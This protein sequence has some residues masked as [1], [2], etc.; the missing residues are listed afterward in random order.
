MSVTFVDYCFHVIY[1]TLLTLFVYV[2]LLRVD[3]IRES[4]KREGRFGPLLEKIALADFNNTT[5]CWHRWIL[6][7]STLVS[8]STQIFPYYC[9]LRRCFLISSCST[10]FLCYVM[11]VKVKD[12]FLYCKVIVQEA[13]SYCSRRLWII[14]FDIGAK[15]NSSYWRVFISFLVL[16][17]IW[18]Q[19]LV[20]FSTIITWK[21]N[22]TVITFVS[23]FI[24]QVYLF[25]QILLF[26]SSA[27]CFRYVFM[28]NSKNK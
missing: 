23:F 28:R 18:K 5:D 22:N 17:V 19:N 16:S 15:H 4:V 27:I 14:L 6:A 11:N 25:L 3:D 7:S 26:L 20:P 10:V 21:L 9:Y 24:V 8:F 1:D 2:F 12:P 13:G